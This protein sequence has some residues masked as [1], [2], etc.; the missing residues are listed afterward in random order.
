MLLVLFAFGCKQKKVLQETGFVFKPIS[1]DSLL[2]VN[3][4]SWEFFSAK[5]D[6][7]VSGDAINQSFGANIKMKKNEFVWL[8]ASMF[9]IEGGRVY[10]QKDSITIINRLNRTYSKIG[11]EKAGAYIGASLDLQ[12]VQNILL[13]NALLENMMGYSFSTDTSYYHVEHATEKQLYRFRADSF[14]ARID[15]SFF[16]GEKSGKHLTLNYANFKNYDGLL[17]PLLINM[18]A[19]DGEQRFNGKIEIQ[20]WDSEAFNVQMRVP[21]SFERIQ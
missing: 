2:V 14:N 5:A 7:N 20:K 3:S 6:V 13:G 21:G 8:S 4:P 12:I 19:K 10:M 17:L 18:K 15:S 9:G 1:M 16:R 11:W